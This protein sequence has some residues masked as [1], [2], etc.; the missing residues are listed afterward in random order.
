VRHFIIFTDHK[1]NTN[2]IQQKQNKCSPQQFNHLDF[3]AQ[4]ATD[5]R[6][7]SGQDNNV[8]NTISRVESITTPPSYE[9]LAASQD[10]D[11]ELQTLLGSTSA[12]RLGKLPI[13]CTTVSICCD[14]S[15]GTSGLRSSSLTAPSVPVC[16]W[17]VSPRHQSSGEAGRTT[18]GVVRHADRLP[19][20]GTCLPVLPLLQSLPPQSLQWVTLDRRQPGFFMSA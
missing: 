3:V 4:F 5:M 12:L 2:V 20:L 18:F 19:H 10:S 8:T 9:A 16:P 11:K 15:A 1:P 17:S 6:H 13:P 14:T 7:I